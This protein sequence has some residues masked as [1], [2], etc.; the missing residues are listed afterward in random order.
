M[1]NYFVFKIHAFQITIHILIYYF[2]ILLVK[3]FNKIIK[4]L[5]F[6][7]GTTQI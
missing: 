5:F 4:F 1:E 3:I 6:I 7:F 2:Q